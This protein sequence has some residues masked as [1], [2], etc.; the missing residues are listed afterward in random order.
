MDLL[1]PAIYQ[2]LLGI[3]VIL[4]LW[5]PIFNEYVIIHEILDVINLSFVNA[6]DIFQYTRQILKIEA[7]FSNALSCGYSL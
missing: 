7:E 2:S 4:V 6:H 3:Y 1:I 5:L